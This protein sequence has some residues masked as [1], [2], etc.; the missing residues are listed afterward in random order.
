MFDVASFL[1]QPLI[2]VVSSYP[3]PVERTFV[4]PSEG[5]PAARDAD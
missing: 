1:Q 2:F 4:H 5:A 3:K